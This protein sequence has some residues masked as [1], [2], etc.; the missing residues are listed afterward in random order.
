MAKILIIDDDGIVRDALSVFLTRAGYEV[1]TA[2]DGA[3]GVQAFKN[4]LPDL[5]VLDRDL[6]VLSGSAVFDSI[7]KIS[8]AM[9]IIVLSGFNAPEEVDAYLRN[10]AAAFLSKGD[11]LS[12]VL[13]EIDRLMGGPPKTG[14]APEKAPERAGDQAAGPGHVPAAG[15]GKVQSAGLVLVADDEPE[16]RRVICRLLA[17]LPCETMEAKDGIAALELARARRPDIILLDISMPGKD[18]LAVLKELAPQMPETGFMMITGNED[19]EVARECLKFGAFDYIS[20]PV[21]LTA[22]CEI[23]KARLLLQK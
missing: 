1:V 6:P 16:I 10:G 17:T 8:N 14:A 9:P 2:A 15:P 11:G 13:A 5:V 20:K 7:R 4:N 19:E 21:N 12:P 3:N 22:L 23:I 18:G